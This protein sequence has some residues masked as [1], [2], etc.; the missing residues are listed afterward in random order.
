M[1]WLAVFSTLCSRFATSYQDAGPGETR[2]RKRGAASVETAQPRLNQEQTLNYNKVLVVTTDQEK[3]IL[4]RYVRV[5]L[6]MDFPLVWQLSWPQDWYL[7]FSP[8][9]PQVVQVQSTTTPNKMY[10]QN[11]TRNSTTSVGSAIITSTPIKHSTTA[12]QKSANTQPSSEPNGT[13]N[14]KQR[15]SFS[16]IHRALLVIHKISQT[17]CYKQSDTMCK[18]RFHCSFRWCAPFCLLCCPLRPLLLIGGKV[19]TANQDPPKEWF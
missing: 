9:G 4:Y 8:A 15:G 2:T 10:A 7:E 14:G 6:D 3:H 16:Q 1:P 5:A 11:I 17:K 12:T 13:D 18:L 19:S